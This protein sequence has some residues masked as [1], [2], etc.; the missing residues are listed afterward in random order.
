MIKIQYLETAKSNPEFFS[1]DS[2]GKQ[3]RDDPL[4]VEVTLQLGSGYKQYIY[5]CD[6]CRRVL[7]RK[8]VALR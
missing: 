8:I 7:H 2:C 6:S 5:F 4:M 3:Y 1:C